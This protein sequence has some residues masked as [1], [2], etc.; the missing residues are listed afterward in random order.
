MAEMVPESTPP[1]RNAP[2]RTSLSRC[3]FT[4]SIDDVVQTVYDVR[5]G[6]GV[7]FA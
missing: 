5:I 1:L 4:E 3:D 7:L 2:T 6:A